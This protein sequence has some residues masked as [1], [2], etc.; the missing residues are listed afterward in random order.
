MSS[1]V[2]AIGAD[3]VATFPP[4]NPASADHTPD[5]VVTLGPPEF[6]RRENGA[7]AHRREP[8]PAFAA[9]VAAT[10]PDRVRLLGTEAVPGAAPATYVDDRPVVGDGRIELARYLREQAVSRTAHRFGVVED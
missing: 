7:V 8:A 9:A 2:P 10:A 1:V 5:P 3:V 4:V 6:M